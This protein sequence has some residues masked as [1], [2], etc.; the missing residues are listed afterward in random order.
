[1]DLSTADVSTADF[2]TDVRHELNNELNSAWHSALRNELNSLAQRST[3][4]QRA[5]DAICYF[6]HP[7]FNRRFRDRRTM[8]DRR[9][10]REAGDQGEQRHQRSGRDRRTASDRRLPRDARLRQ[11]RIELS[12]VLRRQMDLIE[13]QRRG[14]IAAP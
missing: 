14:E 1:M 6:W 12:G 11:L 9:Q 10:E 3:E 8:S 5:I 7:E 13:M 2:A 4:I